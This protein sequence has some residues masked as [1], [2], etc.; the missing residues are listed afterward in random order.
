VR[1]IKEFDMIRIENDALE[2]YKK[3]CE[4]ILLFENKKDVCLILSKKAVLMLKQM[5]KFSD[6]CSSNDIFLN[7]I[8]YASRNGHS[9][10]K[11]QVVENTCNEEL[12]EIKKCLER[13]KSKLS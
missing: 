5:N 12:F 11:I 7:L 6:N 8:D 3:I 2:L 10:L 1:E 4:K 9:I 13:P